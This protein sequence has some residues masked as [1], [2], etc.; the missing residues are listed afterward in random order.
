MISWQ[1]TIV[2]TNSPWLSSINPMGCLSDNILEIVHNNPMVCLQDCHMPIKPPLNPI[3]SPFSREFAGNPW[4]PTSTSH[5]KTAQAETT[6]KSRYFDFFSHGFSKPGLGLGRRWP[7]KP[8]R[9]SLG[10]GGTMEMDKMTRNVADSTGN[11][12][13]MEMWS[14]E[15]LGFLGFLRRWHQKFWDDEYWIDASEGINW[16]KNQ[17]H[18]VTFTNRTAG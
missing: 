18:L 4:K 12:L 5:V 6:M 17:F 13:Q 15:F 2:W 8:R 11:S 9:R 3:G 14:C 7:R 1:T 10:F 16:Y